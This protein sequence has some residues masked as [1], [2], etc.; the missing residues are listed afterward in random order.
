MFF[1]RDNFWK[2][3]NFDSGVRLGERTVITT[4]TRYSAPEVIRAAH[5]GKAQIKL[6][7]S[8][9]VWS[10]GV[11]AYEVLTGDALALC[12]LLFVDIEFS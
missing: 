2:L 1:E 7:T 8:A 4:V 12:W 3:L 5:A 11:M 10:Y 6:D 9:D